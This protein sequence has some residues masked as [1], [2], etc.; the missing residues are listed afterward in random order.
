MREIVFFVEDTGHETVLSSFVQRFATQ[1]NVQIEIVN[2]SAT[3]GHGRVI[4]A[5]DL[6]KLE[7]VEDSLGRFLKALRLQFQEWVPIDNHS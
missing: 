1:Y 6:D 3:G 2:R 4:N 5:M 7:R